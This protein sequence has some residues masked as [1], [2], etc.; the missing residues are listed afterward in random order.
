MDGSDLSIAGI[1]EGAVVLSGGLTDQVLNFVD[2]SGNGLLT[3]SN[4][5]VKDG[6]VVGDAAGF[7]TTMGSLQ[8]EDSVFENNRSINVNDAVDDQGLTG[9]EFKGGAFFSSSSGAPVSVVRSQFIRNEGHGAAFM[10]YGVTTIVR[11]YLQRKYW[12]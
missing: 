5:T 12:C 7:K 6:Y 11:F 10:S 1:G 2:T 8:I 3:L 9:T 4:V